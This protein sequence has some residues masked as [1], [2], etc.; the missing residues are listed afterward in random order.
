MS[1]PPSQGKDQLILAAQVALNA[2]DSASDDLNLL[3]A[4]ATGGKR[5]SFCCANP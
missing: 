2:T 5:L 3:I 4:H 1:R